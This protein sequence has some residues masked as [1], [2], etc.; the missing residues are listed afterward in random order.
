MQAVVSDRIARLYKRL[1]Y[2]AADP[3]HRTY[4]GAA[5]DL[6]RGRTLVNH[7]HANHALD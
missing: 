5:H 6:R 4:S 7:I 3:V 2:R 1:F